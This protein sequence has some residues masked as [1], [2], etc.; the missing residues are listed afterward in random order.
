MASRL[1]FTRTPHPELSFLSGMADSHRNINIHERLPATAHRP[2]QPFRS[3][4][5]V[6]RIGPPGPR[7]RGGSSGARGLRG[8][9]DK[10]SR[11]GRHLRKLIGESLVCRARVWVCFFLF[12]IRV[13]LRR[14]CCRASVCKL[15]ECCEGLSFVGINFCNVS[16]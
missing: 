3:W 5:R 13:F 2:L 12:F 14:L 10:K 7:A 8:L 16:T 4:L 15:R 11:N 6:C 9:R 1:K